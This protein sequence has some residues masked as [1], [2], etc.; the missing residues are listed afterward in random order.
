[1]LLPDRPSPRDIEEI[2]D[3]AAALPAAER[4]A[5]LEAA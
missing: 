5:Y 4:K 2:F 3:V 1:M